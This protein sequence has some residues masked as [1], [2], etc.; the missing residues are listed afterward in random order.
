M[1]IYDREYYR[2]EEQGFRLGG[3]RTMVTNLIL[4]NV[5][6]FVLD[7]F[8]SEHQISNALAVHV[9]DL[10]K[11]W[12]WWHFVTAGFAHYP[13]NIQHIGLNMLGLFFFG[14]Q[15]EIDYGRWEFLR[16]YLAMIV[17]SSIAWC[18]FELVQDPS[19]DPGMYG[20]SGAVSG[21]LVLFA[22]RYPRQIV[23][24]MFLIPVPVW[25]VAV[26]FVVF[27]FLGAL[28]VQPT[29]QA[30]VA[31]TAHLAG[32]AFAFAYYR[33]GWNLGRFVPQNV[34]LPRLKRRPN[35]KIH[36]PSSDERRLNQRV[37]EILAK[38]SLEGEQS[39]TKEERRVLQDA[40]RR[41]QRRRT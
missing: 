30:N 7:Q 4:L 2:E 27:D 32:A 34:R 5:I 11:P 41:Y 31:N 39:L 22:L 38:I 6:L 13:L 20:A 25:L 36:D 12:M 24:L 21:V 16:L 28:N 29:G 18:G 40:S 15:I 8:T 1:G 26:L 19:S 33:F 23:Y 14:R 37:D 9:G 10:W 3:Q 17:V 35:L